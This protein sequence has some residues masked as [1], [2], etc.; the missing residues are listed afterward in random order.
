[1][2]EIRKYN[3]EGKLVEIRFKYPPSRPALHRGVSALAA[4]NGHVSN[5]Q[6]LNYREDLR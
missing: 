2:Q 3:R 6:P 5:H 1:M 4:H